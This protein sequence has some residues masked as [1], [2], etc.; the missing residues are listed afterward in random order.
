MNL[1]TEAE[2]LCCKDKKNEFEDVK[3][4]TWGR[5]K[6][7]KARICVYMPALKY[8]PICQDLPFA[9]RKTSC[10]VRPN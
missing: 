7:Q 10:L 4:V 1:E 3:R 9:L 6:A 5:K 2:F 8:G